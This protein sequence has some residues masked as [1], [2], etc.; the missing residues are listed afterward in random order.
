VL[1]TVG[2]IEIILVLVMVDDTPRVVDLVIVEVA[3]LYN[4]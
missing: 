3:V 1:V 4:N 2:V